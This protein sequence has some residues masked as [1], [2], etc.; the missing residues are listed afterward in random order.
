MPK[1]QCKPWAWLTPQFYWPYGGQMILV[2]YNRSP[3]L[4]HWLLRC[5]G[6]AEERGKLV[7]TMRENVEWQNGGRWE[8]CH[9]VKLCCRD[10]RVG[11]SVEK[12]GR[13]ALWPKLD[14]TCP[15]PLSLIPN[16]L[17]P[18][19]NIWFICYYRLMHFFYVFSAEWGAYT[20]VC[21]CT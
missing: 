11:R 21:C 5:T 3:L 10:N 9:G 16:V 18:G 4:H 15:P 1:V 2:I 17:L 20:L 6:M 8:S 7:M 12:C 19:S 14:C 13:S